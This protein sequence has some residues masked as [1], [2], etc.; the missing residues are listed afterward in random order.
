MIKPNY[1]IIFFNSKV[2]LPIGFRHYLSLNN[3]SKIFL[4][5]SY[6]F[7][8][9]KNSE[10]NIDGGTNVNIDSKNNIS[11]GFGYKFID[12]YSIDFKYQTERKTSGV[13]TNSTLWFCN[14]NS[15]SISLGYTIF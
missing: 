5:V 15:V 8:L 2:K 4:D 10:I 12:K 3:N 13:S 14:Y 1:I 6:I 11:V 9:N 7:D